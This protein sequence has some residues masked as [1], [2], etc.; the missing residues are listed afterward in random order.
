[1]LLIVMIIFVG[2]LLFGFP[3]LMAMGIGAL[4]YATVEGLPASLI[5][6]SIFQALN[7][8]PLIAGPLF[9][10]MGTLVNEF[11][12][13]ER[14]YDF[15]R[16]LLRRGR[17]YTA[18]VNVIVSLIFSGI[19]GSAVADIG[20]L[21]QV[22]IRAMEGEGYTTAYAAALTSASSTI[23]PMFPPSIPLIIYAVTAQISTLRALLAGAL[24]ALV[25]TL[26]LYI[27]V[28][29]QTPGKLPG[30]P[31]ARLQGRPDSDRDGE[32]VSFSKAFGDAFPILLLIPL[33][34]TLM[35]VG[36]FSPSEAGAFAVIYIIILQVVRR[37]FSLKRLKRCLVETYKSIACIFMIIAIAEFLTKV[38]TLEHFP[39][40]VTRWFTSITASPI[41]ILLLINAMV[42]IIGMFM[43]M[44][45]TLIILTPILLVI[46][47]AIG[48]DPFHLG[49]ILVF[50]LEIGMFTPPL[51]VG[52][53]TVAKVGNVPPDKVFRELLTLY[54]PLLIALLIITFFPALS[55]WLPG[56]MD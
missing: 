5:S 6:Y 33:I 4:L 55:L 25:I 45:S 13:T 40:L 7:S 27:F 44:V 17:G 47:N 15:A 32:N 43:E 10:L 11:G 8:F 30:V 37:T 54:W 19:S 28:V 56:L 3:V 16:L 29:L 52:V 9:I 38:L 18:K 23:G 14:I 36:V 49:V 12:E 50:N 53:Y 42:L 34:I 22:E 21:G 39:E 20:G 2:F 51:G 35:L 41:T 48:V 31:A 26:V 46:T 24:P 1:M